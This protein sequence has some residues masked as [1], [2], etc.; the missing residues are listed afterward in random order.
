[1]RFVI[2]RVSRASVTVDG[3]TVG[4]IGPGFMVLAGFSADDGPD[5]PGSRAWTAMLRKL[6]DLRVFSDEAGKMNLALGDIGGGLLVVPQFTLY[7]DCRKGRRPS[8]HPAAHPDVAVPLF[9]ALLS[10]LAALRGAPVEQGEF[11]ADMDV[12][13]VNQGPVTILLDSGDF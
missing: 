2:Q 3:Q 11:G 13:L 12:S 9:E 7:A 4:A 8:F 1:M 6:L 10:D 5:L